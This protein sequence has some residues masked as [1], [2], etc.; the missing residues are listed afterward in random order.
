[1]GSGDPPTP[2]I[3]PSM[4]EGQI[5]P[6]RYTKCLHRLA[7]GK[8]PGPDNIPAEILK[9]LPAPF[10]DALILLFQGMALEGYTPPEW[11]TSRTCLIYKKGDPTLLDNY[12]PIALAVT[13]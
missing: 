12:R 10:H 9:A 6:Q 4:F 1:M 5:T 8:A 7:N 3:S 2:L 11:T 13:I